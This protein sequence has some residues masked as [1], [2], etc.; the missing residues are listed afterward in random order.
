MFEQ[1]PEGNEGTSQE[2]SGEEY[3]RKKNIYINP[4]VGT[5]L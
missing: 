2:I 4:E 1:G 5:C 3:S